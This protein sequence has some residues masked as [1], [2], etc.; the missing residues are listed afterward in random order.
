MCSCEWPGRLKCLATGLD[1][2]DPLFL[3]L[4]KCSRKRSPNLRPDPV[5]TISCLVN[6]VRLGFPGGHLWFLIIDEATKGL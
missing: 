3:T 1:R 6:N 4:S 2:S 5:I